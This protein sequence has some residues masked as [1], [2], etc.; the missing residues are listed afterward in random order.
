MLK[1][2]LDKMSG[3]AKSL[4][5]RENCTITGLMLLRNVEVQQVGIQSEI[6]TDVNISN[7]TNRSLCHL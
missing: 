1:Y 6:L 3:A 5:F 2:G 7:F 4:K